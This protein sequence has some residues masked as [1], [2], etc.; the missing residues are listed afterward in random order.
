MPSTTFKTFGWIAR[1][2]PHILVLEGEV[3]KE[4]DRIPKEITIP[5]PNIPLK[6]REKIFERGKFWPTIVLLE[7]TF[8][9]GEKKETRTFARVYKRRYNLFI[10]ILIGH[11]MLEAS[12]FANRFNIPLYSVNCSKKGNRNSAQRIRM[13]T[14]H[15]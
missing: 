6:E 11:T 3:I 8:N 7:K 15:F 1:Q 2:K 4:V 14:A 12:E 13:D 9:S 10:D 5:D